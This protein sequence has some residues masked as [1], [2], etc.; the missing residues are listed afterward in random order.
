[1]CSYISIPHFVV[2]QEQ[3]TNQLKAD[4]QKVAAKKKQKRTKVQARL[5]QHLDDV[6][7]PTIH[8]ENLLPS[9]SVSGFVPVVEQPR[10]S[11]VLMDGQ[12]NRN[13]SSLIVGVLQPHKRLNM[14]EKKVGDYVIVAYF[15]FGVDD[16]EKMEFIL[17]VIVEILPEPTDAGYP[18]LRMHWWNTPN[19]DFNGIFKQGWVQKGKPYFGARKHHSHDP[20]VEEFA[21]DGKILAHGKLLKKNSKLRTKWLKLLCS[22]DACNFKI[23][24]HDEFCDCM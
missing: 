21:D 24:G 5:V 13:V 3:K 16:D 12:R 17:G 14:V 11:S 10:S 2:A 7:H 8:V 22:T 15:P 9:L 6:P 19:E 23:N 4:T 20:Y 18:R 1:M